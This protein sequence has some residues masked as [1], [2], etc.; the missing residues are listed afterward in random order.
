M[1]ACKAVNACLLRRWA[2][3]PLPDICAHTHTHTHTHTRR[4]G[5]PSA[6]RRAP[7]CQATLNVLL[8]S[9]TQLRLGCPMDPLRSPLGPGIETARVGAEVSRPSRT[10]SGSTKKRRTTNNNTLGFFIH[11]FWAGR[12]SPIWGVWEAPGG[13]ETF[14]KGGGLCPPYFSMVSRASGAAQ[15]PKT[16]DFRPAQQ[17]CIKKPSIANWATCQVC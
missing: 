16:D 1:N 14:Q 8:P 3:V 17:P 7:A 10:S 2:S 5:L 9:G 6:E 12:K 13:R 4:A 15:T 11:G